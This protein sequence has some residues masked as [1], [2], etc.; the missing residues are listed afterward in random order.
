M[1][2]WKLAVAAAVALT[3]SGAGCSAPQDAARH[4]A[5]PGSG[6]EGARV[7]GTFRETA[8]PSGGP[9]AASPEAPRTD[10]TRSFDARV[11][12]GSALDPTV[13]LVATSR[14]LARGR[15]EAQY[16]DKQRRRYDLL[17]TADS[18]GGPVTRVEVALEGRRFAEVTLAW[19]EQAGTWVLT[20][21]E[22][23]FYHDGAVLLRRHRQAGEIQVAGAGLLRRSGTVLANALLP[24]PAEAAMACS[25]EWIL[26][27]SASLAVVITGERAATQWWNLSAWRN[28]LAAAGAWGLAMDALIECMTLNA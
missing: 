22:E 15:R 28:Y 13:G 25:Q 4:L 5:G 3:V 24:A 7:S 9:A 27:A 19:R 6:L 14:G 8:Q 20:N 1:T 2:N 18:P 26:Y 23:V 17:A 11:R 16:R 10:T 12:G 21:R